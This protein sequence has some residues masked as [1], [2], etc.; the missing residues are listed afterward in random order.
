MGADV[1]EGCGLTATRG[2]DVVDEVT[3]FWAGEL[4]G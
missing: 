2:G 4:G 1:S 3:N